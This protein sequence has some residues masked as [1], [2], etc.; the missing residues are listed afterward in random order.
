MLEWRLCLTSLLSPASICTIIHFIRFL[1]FPSHQIPFPVH[2]DEPGS[3]A[4]NCFKLRYISVPSTV[5]SSVW[6][7]GNPF[8]SSQLDIQFARKSCN[9]LSMH[10]VDF[11]VRQSAFEASIHDS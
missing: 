6:L 4:S 7:L 10:L 5:D 1:T 2:V 3:F 11:F 9:N 8:V